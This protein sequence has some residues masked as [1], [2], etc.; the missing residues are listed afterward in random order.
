MVRAGWYLH[1][2][3][4]VIKER[5]SKF[6][7]LWSYIRI[8]ITDAFLYQER[9]KKLMFTLQS[10]L[11]LLY[12]KIMSFSWSYSR[13][14]DILKWTTL[15]YVITLI[16]LSSVHFSHSVLSDSLQSHGLQQV[17]PPCPSKTSRVNPNSCS[18]SWWWHS[19]ISSSVV[20]FSCLQS[21]RVSGSFQMNQFFTSVAKVLKFQIQH[22]CI[23]W[24]FR[25]GCL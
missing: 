23:Q 20:P 2:N 18:L 14:E 1:T 19:T 13:E 5:N 3:E 21:L 17:S 11:I 22:Q 16:I 6:M 7:R 15:E 8:L 10:R 25:T 12:R 24:I 9:K 4:N